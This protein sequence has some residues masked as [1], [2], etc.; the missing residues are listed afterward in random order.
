MCTSRV[1]DTVLRR[2]E[3]PEMVDLGYRITEGG[4]MSQAIQE[5]RKL[6]GQHVLIDLADG[7]ILSDYILVSAGRGRRVTLWLSHNDDDV[8]LPLAEVVAVSPGRRYGERRAA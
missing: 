8:F 2:I 4:R 5:L 6:E 3:I 7:S 1:G